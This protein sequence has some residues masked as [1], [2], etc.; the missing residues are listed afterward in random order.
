LVIVLSLFGFE[1]R[2]LKL[3]LNSIS[4]IVACPSPPLMTYVLYFLLILC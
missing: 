4:G 1:I 2:N 3:N